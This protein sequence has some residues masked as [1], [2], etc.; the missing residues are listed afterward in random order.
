MG[1]QKKKQKQK[2]KKKKKPEPEAH[3]TCLVKRTFH[4]IVRTTD[5]GSDMA[6]KKVDDT[7]VKYFATCFH[8]I[9]RNIQYLM[10]KPLNFSIQVEKD[11]DL[12]LIVLFVAMSVTELWVYGIGFGFITNF[13]IRC[14][15]NFNPLDQGFKTM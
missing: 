3:L 7:S 15:K 14:C 13:K 2:K 12:K 6:G 4:I 10:Q 11:N 9:I 5:C 1:R 8:E